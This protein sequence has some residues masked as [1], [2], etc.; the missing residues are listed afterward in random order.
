MYGMTF[1]YICSFHNMVHIAGS[2]C[3]F[4]CYVQFEESYEEEDISVFF[5]ISIKY[6]VC[7]MEAVVP[8]WTP[9]V[10]RF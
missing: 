3:I 9:E 6:G 2:T 8:S 10:P 1:N 5:N 7:G 4:R